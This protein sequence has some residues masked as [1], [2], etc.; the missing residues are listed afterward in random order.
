MSSSAP[1]AERRRTA[2]RR[3]FAN[4]RPLQ[5]RTERRRR[6]RFSVSSSSSSSVATKRHQPGQ[7][8]PGQAPPGATRRQATTA[9]DDSNF[10]NPRRFSNHGFGARTGARC[11]GAPSPPGTRRS[12]APSAAVAV[13]FGRPAGPTD[14]NPLLP[15]TGNQPIGLCS[16]EVRSFR[17]CFIDLSLPKGGPRHL[18]SIVMIVFPY[19]GS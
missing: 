2:A 6:P 7:G 9:G 15:T 12:R 16:E 17:C 4:N 5:S 11:L 14:T 13:S 3:N 8:R 10:R 1:R 18:C 19:R